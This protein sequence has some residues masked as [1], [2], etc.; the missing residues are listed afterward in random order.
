M[1][2]LY[3]LTAQ[4]RE[5]QTLAETSDEEMAEAIRDTFEAHHRVGITDDALEAAVD[6]SIRYISNRFLPDKA[7]AYRRSELGR[8]QRC[9]TN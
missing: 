8:L 2:H 7:I 4:S 9:I 5:L 6:L 1:T 3:E